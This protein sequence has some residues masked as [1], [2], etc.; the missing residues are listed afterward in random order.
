[1]RI[2]ASL[3]FAAA[4]APAA[5]AGAAPA[6]QATVLGVVTVDG[7]QSLTRLD[8]LTLRPT[9]TAAV[10][11]PTVYGLSPRSPDG[12]QLAVSGMGGPRLAFVD[13]DRMQPLGTM[14]PP[15][16][17]S[18][19]LICWP[20][21]RRLYAVT[22]SAVLVIDPVAR[23]VV[24]RVP[25]R[26][27]MIATATSADGAAVLTAPIKGIGTAHVLDVNRDGVA[28]RVTLARIRAGSNWRTKY[29]PRGT[30]RRPGF[31]V[32]TTGQHAYVVDPGGLVA[33][34][35]LT[36]FAVSYR[37]SRT[38]AR[39]DKE[40]TGPVRYATWLGDGRIAVSGVNER[41]DA[42]TPAGLAILDTRSWTSRVV[43]S[44]ASWFITSSDSIVV[45]AGGRLSVYDRDGSVRWRI[46]V[47]AQAYADVHGPYVYLWDGDTVRVLDGAS[48]ATVTT[49]PKPDLWLVFGD[50]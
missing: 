14:T 32:D 42:W 12:T 31:A 28:R 40:L 20:E 41:G 13:I 9:S 3:L 50:A 25:L 26:G 49:L 5:I 7:K 22:L 43:D 47:T 8:A 11:I 1:V 33:V 17:T 23:S 38:F 16:A 19:Q 45:V 10:A 21:Q 48:G 35:D 29:P 15:A 4:L 46:A 2:V 34:V 37:G 44:T 39:A 24:A 36:T 27:S 18:L 6:P 30:T